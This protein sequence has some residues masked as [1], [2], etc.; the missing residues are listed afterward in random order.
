MWYAGLLTGVFP[1]FGITLYQVL[2]GYLEDCLT[3]TLLRR[4]DQIAVSLLTNIDQTGERYVAEQIKI[5]YAPENYD[6]F[7]RIIRPDGSI[8]YA[9]GQTASFDPSGLRRL[10]IN[11]VH[12]KLAQKVSLSNGTHLLDITVQGKV[13]VN[14]DRARIKQ[15]VVNPLDNANKYTPSGGLINLD[16]SARENKAVIE[17]ADTGI[18]IP[19]NALPHIFERFFRAG[20]RRARAMRADPIWD[21]RLL[22]RFAWPTA[23]K[24]VCKAAKARAAALKWNC[25]SPDD[26]KIDEL[27]L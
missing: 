20:T 2:R 7:I 22:N 6:R 16:V 17:V 19:T 27:T 26:A 18:G 4:S 9:S 24:S 23:V 12:S 13:S 25:H 14:G 10:G 15:V 8:L 1:L 11:T 3:Q 5:R 21:W